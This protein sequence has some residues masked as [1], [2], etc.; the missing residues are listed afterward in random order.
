VIPKIPVFNR[1]VIQADLKIAIGCVTTHAQAGFSGSAKRFLPGVAHVVSI[2]HCHLD[3][4]SMG[5]ETTGM[6]RHGS[7][8]LHREINEAAAPWPN[9]TTFVHT[10]IDKPRNTHKR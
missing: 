8:I 2:S 3:V 6:V 1:E 10:E 4:E 9:F 7:N 5:M